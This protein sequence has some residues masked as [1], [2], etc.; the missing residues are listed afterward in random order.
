VKRTGPAVCGHTFDGHSCR[1]RG[2]HYCRPRAAHVVAFFNELLVHPV[3]DYAR[4]PF[5]LARWQR[6]RVIEPLFGTVVWDTKRK[7]YVRRYRELYLLLPRKSGKSELLAGI[8]LFLL[9]GEGEEA[10]EIYGLALDKDQA[11]HVYRR[12]ARMVELSPTLSKR[13]EVLRSTGRIVDGRTASFLAVASGDAEG[14]LGATPQGAYIDELLTQ[15]DRNVYDNLRTGMGT[16][17]QPLLMMATTAEA[18]PS[19]FAA[20]EREESLLVAADPSRNPQRLVVIYQ[21]AYDDDWAK[22]ATWRKASPAL[23]DFL[24][25]SVLRAEFHRAQLNPV[26]ERAFRQFRLNQA[27]RA[28]GRAIDLVAWDRSAGLV[29]E[30][31]LV[32]R[33]CH[34][35]LD[36][37]TTTD[38]AALA[39]DFPDPED[40]ELHQ[41]VWRLFCPEAA[42]PGFDRSTAGQASVWARQGRLEVTEGN[43]I[44]YGA[45]KARIYVDAEQ[46]SV[47]DVAYDRWGATQL[48]QE[49]TDE[50]LEM[51]GMGQGFASM[52]APTKELLRLIAAGRYH[53]GGNPAVRWQAEHVVT[54]QDPAGNLKVDK[55]KSVE[56]V[57]GI[58]AAVMALDRAMRHTG[59][60]RRPYAAASF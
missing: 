33:R 44:D 26:E 46:F 41:V 52:S 7:R 19:S 15:P 39:W 32:G 22:E 23:G 6:R 38:L 45:I 29:V 9:V 60:Q 3:G 16:R 34:G 36:L 58:V 25:I 43:V 8:C 40:P 17:A 14:T 47:V 18:D 28:V 27:V 55:A 37:A 35:G 56:K 50:G 49:L 54:R 20:A 59:D 42:L 2:A 11:G 31:H 24:D 1:K 13:L 48:V 57:D 10:A 51:V 21:A 4:Q 53:H 5:V 30:D 12:A